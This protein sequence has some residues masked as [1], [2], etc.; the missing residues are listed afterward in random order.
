MRPLFSA[1][2]CLLL[3]VAPMHG[4]GFDADAIARGLTEGDTAEIQRA[5][6]E[7]VAYLGTDLRVSDRLAADA[8]LGA[9]VDE[10][11]GSDDEFRVV[12]ALLVAG[13]LVT[14]TSLQ[15]LTPFLD[16]ER[17]GVRYT[18]LKSLR[19]S[20]EIL[21]RQASP[22]LQPDAAMSALSVLERVASA[23]RDPAAIEAALR[24]IAAAGSM[25]SPQMRVLQDRAAIALPTI[26]AEHL[27]RLEAMDDDGLHT[28]TLGAIL[29]AMLE[30]RIDLSNRDARMPDNAVRAA[31]KLGGDMIAYVFRLYEKGQ[32]VASISQERREPLA[33][34]ISAS[35]TLVFFALSRLGADV[36]RTTIADAFQ[37]ADDRAFRAG[38]LRV[39]GPTGSLSQAGVQVAG[40]PGAG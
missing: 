24:A 21:S 15:K 9:S 17:P 22:S 3:L 32:T 12:N 36:E 34:A 4:Q 8:A 35:E 25:A 5:R 1:L 27:A 40:G 18:A 30:L 2:S 19:A 33:Q 37:N 29:Y 11:L 10:A 38:V 31:A 23:E 16:D 6:S 13:H 28:Q 20:L 7:A 39:I 14:P 26:A